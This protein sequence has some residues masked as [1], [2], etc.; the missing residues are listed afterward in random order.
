MVLLPAGLYRGRGVNSYELGESANGNDQFQLPFTVYYE[1]DDGN[2]LTT[3]LSAFLYFNTEKVADRSFESIRYC[4]WDGVDPNELAPPYA[5]PRKVDLSQEVELDIEVSEYEG[6]KRNKIRFINR[7][8][9]GRPAKPIA[10]DR[11]KAWA[12]SYKR[13]EGVAAASRAMPVAGA[14]PAAAPAATTTRAM[15]TRA[16][17]AAAPAAAPV[18]QARPA[19]ARPAPARAPAPAPA[20]R[21][22]AEEPAG[23]EDLPPDGFG[24]D[25][26]IPF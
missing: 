4:G 26:E 14:R 22:E 15:P 20:P 6:K 25:D 24:S 1:D 18:A 5:N 17:P 2:Q 13:P 21:Q 16:A 3:T 7:I 19:A 8:G 10:E 23:Q 12:S 9:G 11:K